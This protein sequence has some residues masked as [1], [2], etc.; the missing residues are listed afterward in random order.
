MKLVR[1]ARN[2]ILASLAWRYIARRR[3]LARQRRR[4]RRIIAPALIAGGAGMVWATRRR[5]AAGALRA[6]E[7]ATR[8]VEWPGERGS[9]EESQ[10]GLRQPEQVEI[11]TRGPRKAATRPTSAAGAPDYRE[12]APS[13]K[14]HRR[15][16]RREHA[17]EREKAERQSAKGGKVNVEV[18]ETPELRAP[19]GDLKH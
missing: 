10:P 3:A 9:R 18:K 13:T 14:K 11:P 17:Q 1:V 12:P 2:V 5:I 6:L 8:T 16:V 19:L 4:V 7:V 15:R